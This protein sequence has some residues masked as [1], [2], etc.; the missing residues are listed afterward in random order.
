MIVQV[1]PFNS[2]MIGVPVS[3]LISSAGESPSTP[4]SAIPAEGVPPLLVGSPITSIPA[5]PLA[6]A[7]HQLPQM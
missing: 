5:T 3:R 2:P 1:H 4:I 6:L 7:N